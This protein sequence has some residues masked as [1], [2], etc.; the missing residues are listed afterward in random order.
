MTSKLPIKNI[1]LIKLRLAG[2]LAIALLLLLV[3]LLALPETRFKLHG[4]FIKKTI[5][6]EV[7][8]A[9]TGYPIIGATVKIGSSTAST[10]TYG[11]AIFKSI[12]VGAYP[13]SI[14]IGKDSVLQEKFKVSLQANSDPVI[15]RISSK[16]IIAAKSDPQ[17]PAARSIIIGTVVASHTTGNNTNNGNA[18]GGSNGNSGNG[19][20]GG[21]NGSLSPYPANIELDGSDP[22][23]QYNAQALASPNIMA[24]DIRMDWATVEPSQGIF[25]WTGLDNEAKA[26]AA[27]GK[28]FNLIIRYVSEYYGKACNRPDEYLPLWE[29]SRLQ[30]NKLVFC[31]N[32]RNYIPD[33]FDTTTFQPDLMTYISAIANHVAQSSYKN[34]LLYVRIGLGAGGEGIPCLGCDSSGL[35]QLAA[36]GLHTP[37]DWKNWQELMFDKYRTVFSNATLIYD[38]GYKGIDPNTGVPVD[39]EVAKYVLSE[40]DGIGQEGLSPIAGYDNEVKFFAQER[41]LYPNAYIQFATGSPLVANANPQGSDN[42]C[43]RGDI[44]CVLKYDIQYA[45]QA[46]VFSVE[47]YP[48]DAG[49]ASLQSQFAQWQTRVNSKFGD[50]HN[51]APFSQYKG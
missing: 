28:K 3:T 31:S 10:D 26:W 15:F 44:A 39:R 2:V 33:Y 13:L 4:L 49:N 8:E 22:Y 51:D 12:P 42:H 46:G 5:T 34:N 19:G 7:Q 41:A 36:W 18:N 21:G 48:Q 24:T 43:S 14:W 9:T 40:G 16:A 6:A 29:V 32:N 27:A 11:D 45:D 25:D 35:K 20:G 23:G 47:W 38:L 30:A 50:M 37:A 1:W 17:N